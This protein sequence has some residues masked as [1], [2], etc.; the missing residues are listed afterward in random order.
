MY[1][2]FK[3]VKWWLMFKKE[4]RDFEIAAEF[5]KVFQEDETERDKAVGASLMSAE[6]A[7]RKAEMVKKMLWS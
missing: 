6:T 7:Q 2:L 5:H 4:K 3:L 1:K